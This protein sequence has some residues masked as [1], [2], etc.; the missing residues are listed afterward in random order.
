VEPDSRALQTEAARRSSPQDLFNGGFTVAKKK[1]VKKAAPK[2][3]AKKKVAKKKAV[4]R[5]KK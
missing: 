4:K 3:V 2:K 1:R 5:K